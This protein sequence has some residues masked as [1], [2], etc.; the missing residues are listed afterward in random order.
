MAINI[1]I[2]E[3]ILNI[4]KTRG[5]QGANRAPQTGYSKVSLVGRVLSILK[6]LS[7]EKYFTVL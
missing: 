5:V 7:H 2:Y 1:I 3:E 4:Y 6:V